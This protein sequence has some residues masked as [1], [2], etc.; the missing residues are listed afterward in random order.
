[1]TED[2]RNSS[3]YCVSTMYQ[4]NRFLGNFTYH[5]DNLRYVDTNEGDV[6]SFKGIEHIYQE[7]EVVYELLYHGGLLKA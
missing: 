6:S 7:E 2:G 4:E 5:M 1:M 3:L